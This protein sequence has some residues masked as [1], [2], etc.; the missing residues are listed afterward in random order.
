MFRGEFQGLS[1][2]R[3]FRASNIDS[4]HEGFVGRVG[5]MGEGVILSCSADLII[6]AFE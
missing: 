4:V 5:W 1:F 6:A 3:L 2:S